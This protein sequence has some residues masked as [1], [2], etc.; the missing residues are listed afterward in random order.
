MTR[1][2]STTTTTDATSTKDSQAPGTRFP[3]SF[4]GYDRHIVDDELRRID[5]RVADHERRAERLARHLDETRTDLASARH[6]LTR[7]RAE[8]RYWNDRASYVDSEVARA[9]TLADEI[10]SAARGRADAIEADAQERSLQLVDR[11][12]TEANAMLQAA[13][14]EARE[15]FMRFETDVDMSKQKLDRLETVRR[16]VARTMQTAIGQFEDAVRELDTVAPTKRIVEA[17]EMP[18]RKSLPTFGKQRAIEAADRFEQGTNRQA[19]QAMTSPVP[20]PDTTAAASDADTSA[21]MSNAYL[22]EDTSDDMQQTIADANRASITGDDDVTRSA[23]AKARL[24]Y[25][26]DDEF[27]ALLMQP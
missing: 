25:D 4:H 10:E 16:D 3:R 1:D 9:R 19:E 21:D 27:A 14:E 22:V 13:R 5:A 17:V 8:L 7:A 11:V 18:V 23:I 15:M 26:A 24:V 6:E 2:T 20:E 12:C